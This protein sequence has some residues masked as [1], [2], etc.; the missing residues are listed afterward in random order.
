MI[1][2]KVDLA[3]HSLKD[4]PLRTPEGLLNACFPLRED[5]RG[6]A[7]FKKRVKVK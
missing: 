2:G 3:V 6:C 5:N 1:E 4:M 7:Y